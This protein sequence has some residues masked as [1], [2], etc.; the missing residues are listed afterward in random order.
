MKTYAISLE[1]A[2]QRFIYIRNHL[3]F[4]QMDYT[5]IEAIDGMKFTRKD[6][7][8]YSNIE[9]VDAMPNWLTNGAIACALS[10]QEAYKQLLKS[11]DHC[12]F[13]VE[14]DVVLPDNIKD[15]LDS[16]SKEI[17]SSEI[18]LLYY[19][20]FKPAK[21]SVVDVVSVFKST[22]HYPVDIQQPIA[23][24]A[25]VIGRD[26]AKGLIIANTPIQVA[27]DCWHFFHSNQAF[28]SL[29]VVYPRPVKIKYFKSTLDYI[30]K[31][32]LR[33]KLSY[34][35]DHYRIPLL[36]NYLWHKRKLRINKMHQFSLSDQ[37]SN[38][39]PK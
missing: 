11:E 31:K 9:R 23:A 4:R 26:A 27:A 19:V 39:Q 20:S 24:T 17:K 15:L 30:N 16:L 36:Y 12:A 22:L 29:R 35:V 34:I 3:N 13:I 18:I 37:T 28:N 14:D 5:L 1:R 32:S 10:H 6:I 25:Y 21:L 2:K 33:G 7:E 8:K 38:I